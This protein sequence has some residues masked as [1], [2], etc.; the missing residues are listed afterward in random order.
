[1]TKEPFGISRTDG[2]RPGGLNLTPW[3]PGKFLAVNFIVVN[4][5]ADS[6]ISSTPLSADNVAEITIERKILKYST[7]PERISFQP[8]AFEMLDPINQSGVDV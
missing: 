5:L 7:L 2:K 8:V 4:T 3:Q 6:Y 1:L